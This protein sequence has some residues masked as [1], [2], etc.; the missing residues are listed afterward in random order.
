MENDP[1]LSS[2]YR[3]TF[4]DIRD[5]KEF[6]TDRINRIHERF[7]YIKDPENLRN[8][9]KNEIYDL[10]KREYPED[11]FELTTEFSDEGDQEIYYRYKTMMHGERKDLELFERERT[12]ILELKKQQ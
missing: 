11:E 4:K 6:D 1:D 9:L 8:K 5:E 7:D 10:T 12:R 3:Q 2:Q